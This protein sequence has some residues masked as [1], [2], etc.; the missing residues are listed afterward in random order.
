M[1]PMR[2]VRF[3]IGMLLAGGLVQAAAAQP[4]LPLQ[5]DLDHAVFAYDAQGSMLEVYLAFG[6][7]S[8][9]FTREGEAFQARLPLQV[10]VVRAAQAEV[11]GASRAPV[12]QDSLTLGFTVPDTSALEAGQNFV[13][14]LRTSVPPGEYELQLTLP[15]QGDRAELSLRRDIIVPDFTNTALAGL[16]DLTLAT[17]IRRSEERDNPFYKNGLLVQP[18]PNQLFGV[19]LDRLYYYTEAYHAQQVAAGDSAYTVFAYIA[20]ANL[21]QPLPRFQRRNPR[22]VRSPDVLFGFFDLAELPSGSYFLRVAL[23][24]RNNEAIVEQARKFFVYNPNVQRTNPTIAT[25]AEFETSPYA[26]M[27][28]A[29]L[30]KEQE[31]LELVATDQERRRIRNIV[32]LDERRRFHME[33]WQ[34][35]DPNPNTPLNEFKE[36]FYRRL[37]YANDRYTSRQQEGWKTDRGRVLIKYGLPT[38][39]EPHLYD[40]ELLPHEIW[41]YNNIPGEGQAEFIFADR[42]GLGRFDLLHSTVTGERKSNDWL[43]LLQR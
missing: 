36:E 15:A 29:E 6:A 19:G 33:F 35:R 2:R 17:L 43:S 22:P 24:N 9:P 13:H 12:W 4:S 21:P 23:L 30:D 37:Q 28:E 41:Q 10:A 5:I 20:E 18:N 8:L 31:H 40:R 1:M 14:Q 27:S 7:S 32:D 34:K 42:D 3:L 26:V 16:S 39:I 11:P 38:G 25:D